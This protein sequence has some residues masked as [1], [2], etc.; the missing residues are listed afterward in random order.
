MNYW[1][2][3]LQQPATSNQ[4]PATSNQQP[5]TSNQQPATSNQ[6][7]PSGGFFMAAMTAPE[8]ACL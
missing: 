8:Q 2:E 7:P 4:Q 6:Q 3:A 1:P 5:A